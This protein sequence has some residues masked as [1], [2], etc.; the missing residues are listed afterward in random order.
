MT[1]QLTL[2]EALRDDGMRKAW[3]AEGPPWK[4]AAMQALIQLADEGY[5]FTSEDVRVRAGDP[6][7]SNA[8]GALFAAAA[9]A[10]LIEQCGWAKA[11]RPGMHATDLRCWRGTTRRVVDVKVAGGVL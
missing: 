5:P 4:D 7:R 2:G 3:H 1:E 11:K 9:R 8:V 10:G 6:E